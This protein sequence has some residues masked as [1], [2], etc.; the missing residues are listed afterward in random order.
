MVCTVRVSEYVML[1]KN[2]RVHFALTQATAVCRSVR[3][4]ND[5]VTVKNWL[6]LHSTQSVARSLSFTLFHKEACELTCLLLVLVVRSLSAM[7][8]DFKFKQTQR[9]VGGDRYL[10][11][12][13]ES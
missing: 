1:L 8:C 7:L 10:S 6:L 2:T 9:S 4:P 5:W 11:V 3:V 13:K 12:G